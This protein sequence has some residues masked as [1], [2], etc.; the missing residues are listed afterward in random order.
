VNVISA[1]SKND[2]ISINFSENVYSEKSVVPI[3]NV[4]SSN[5]NSFST[6]LGTASQQQTFT[7]SGSGLSNDISISVPSGYEI[8]LDGTTWSTSLSLAIVGSGDVSTRTINIRIAA[9]ASSGSHNGAVTISSG[10]ENGN[11]NITGNVNS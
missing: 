7:V 1:S 8:S 6:C 11:F 10:S 3:I 5:I 9:N 2:I 4:N